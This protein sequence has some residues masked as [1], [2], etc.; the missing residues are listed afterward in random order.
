MSIVRNAGWRIL[1]GIAAFGLLAAPSFADFINP[2]F[3]Q[4][5]FNG[6][7]KGGGTWQENSGTGTVTYNPTGDPGKSA[8]ISGA[9]KMDPLTNNQL[10]EVFSG[11]YSA[12]VNNSDSG[13]HYSTLSQAVTWTD[14]NL[15][16]AWAAVL[17]EPSNQHPASA[18]PNFSIRVYDSTKDAVLYSEHFDVYNPPNITGFQWNEGATDGGGTW[19][20]SDWIV[21]HMDTSAYKG[22]LI[23]LSMTAADCGWGGHGGYAYLDEFSPTAPTPNPGVTTFD[24]TLNEVPEPA[25]MALMT[26]GA[27]FLL[28]RRRARQQL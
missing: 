12:R 10:H 16:F 28:K 5:T 2:G 1:V 8:I 24:V 13:Y 4:G 25:S 3:E 15:Y 14:D 17:Q 9:S 21:V 11:N 19:R 27:A 22:D 20:Y 23:T 18:A 6:W 26:L 7:S